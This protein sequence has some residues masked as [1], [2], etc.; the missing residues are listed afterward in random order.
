MS[1]GV[2]HSIMTRKIALPISLI[3]GIFITPILGYLAGALA[4]ISCLGGFIL[5]L[6]VNPDSDQFGL[7]T[8]EWWLVKKFPVFGWSLVAIFDPYCRWIIPSH[9]HFLSHGYII[10]TIIRVIYLGIIFGILGYFIPIIG[11]VDKF[12]LYNYDIVIYITIGMIISDFFH[13]LLDFNL[14]FREWF[15]TAFVPEQYQSWQKKNRREDY[16]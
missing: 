3:F 15:E 6:F 10:G 4:F 16:G 1:N 14:G 9:R 7:T 13:E 12:L 8:A 2:S 11:I 5:T